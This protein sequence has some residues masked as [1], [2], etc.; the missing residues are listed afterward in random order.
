MKTIDAVVQVLKEM[1]EELREE[2]WDYARNL[3]ES[4]T[5]KTAGKMKLD[6]RGLLRDMREE[7]TS[8][9]LQHK[10]TEWR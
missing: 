2:V 10:L 8:V 9:Q 5:P 4:R 7:Y 6:W 3:K 1:P